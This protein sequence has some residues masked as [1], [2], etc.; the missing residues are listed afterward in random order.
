MK[1]L[2]LVSVIGFVFHLNIFG[3]PAA[4]S[5]NVN[6]EESEN[7]KTRSLFIWVPGVFT[8]GASLFI[9]RDKEPELKQTL[10]FL[11][12]IKI[13]ILNGNSKST[14]WKRK[15][16]R[17]E[18]KMKRKKLDDLMVVKNEDSTVL[19]KAGPSRKGKIKKYALLVNSDDSAVLLI[20]KSRLDFKKLM[21]LVEEVSSE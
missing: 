13:R 12:G 11:G 5:I 4:K 8:K 3:Q 7:E 14:K 20:G 18:R 21:K 2:I 16:A 9:N 19:M 15:T 10:R 6:F 1:R 17:W